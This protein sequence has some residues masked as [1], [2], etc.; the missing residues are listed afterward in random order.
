MSC[1]YI[2]EKDPHRLEGGGRK[3]KDQSNLQS[4]HAYQHYC[5]LANSVLLYAA[6]L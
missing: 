6:L 1:N 2:P 5:M 4:V 3:L